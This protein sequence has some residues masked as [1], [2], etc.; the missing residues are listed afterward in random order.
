[1][2]KKTVILSF[3]NPIG[4]Q[5]DTSQN[6]FP[7]LGRTGT[8]ICSRESGKVA[9]RRCRWSQRRVLVGFDRWPPHYEGGGGK[10]SFSTMSPSG[11]FIGSTKD[12]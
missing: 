4:R 8:S 10:K 1:M 12:S 7:C 5:T 2:P 11:W 3:L 6:K 9:A